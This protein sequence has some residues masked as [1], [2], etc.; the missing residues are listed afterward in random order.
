MNNNL[1]PFC[2]YN[3]FHKIVAIFDEIPKCRY[4]S[5]DIVLQY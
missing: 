1:P 5:K 2:I 3:H 4:I